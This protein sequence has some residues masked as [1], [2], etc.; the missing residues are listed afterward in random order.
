MP[1][2]IFIKSVKTGTP[3]TFFPDRSL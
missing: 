2:N 3:R 1:L